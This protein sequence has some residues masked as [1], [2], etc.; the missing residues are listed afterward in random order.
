MKGA[1]WRW[2]A[3]SQIWEQDPAARVALIYVP[4]GQESS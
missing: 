1:G 3:R 2:T 4:G